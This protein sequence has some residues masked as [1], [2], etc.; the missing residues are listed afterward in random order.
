[1][2]EFI[3]YLAAFLTTLSFLPQAMKTIKT[4]D[5][6]GI[7]F[8]MYFMFVSGVFFWLIY[9]FLI[10][11]VTILVANLITLIFAGIVLFIKFKAMRK[12]RIK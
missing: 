7:S 11:N 10:S 3:G 2:I 8:L 4:R 12:V 9:G 5:T 1:M 6:S